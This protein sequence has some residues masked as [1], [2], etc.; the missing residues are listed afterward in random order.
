MSQTLSLNA[1][2]EYS[3]WPARLL[4]EVPF[5]EKQ[6]D[7]DLV[8]Q[9]Y[10]QD[11]WGKA[12][13]RF[14][15]SDQVSVEEL[16]CL[17]DFDPE[18]VLPYSVGQDLY[19]GTLLHLYAQYEEYLV[20][21]LSPLKPECLVELGSGLGDKVLRLAGQ[22]NVD[23]VWGGEF[24]ASGVACGEILASKWQIA[25]RFN[26][27]NYH[28]PKTLDWLPEGAVIF[29]SHSIEQI[30]YLSDAFFEKL[31]SKRPRLVMH[32]EP[33]YE[34]YGDNILVDLMRKRYIEV[35]DYNRNLHTSLQKYQ[36]EGR[37]RILDVQKDIPSV[38]PLNPSTLILW[39][40]A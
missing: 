33:H 30:P 16:L 24:T 8:L 1:L 7:P 6:R 5:A 26:H 2:P 11:K 25:A 39:E 34:S 14:Q 28:D 35:N 22:L 4:G 32:V 23:D 12:L 27:F 20:R 19:L 3:P 18:Q 37:I 29:T 38:N 31:F 15:A 36:A 17:Q 13:T 10:E 9:E 21:Y 40:M